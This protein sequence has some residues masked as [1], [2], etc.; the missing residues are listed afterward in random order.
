MYNVIKET[1]MPRAW[2]AIAGAVL[3][4]AGA[5]AR[6]AGAGASDSAAVRVLAH[7]PPRVTVEAGGPGVDAG[8]V[9]AGEF[10]ATAGFRVSAGADRVHLAVSATDLHKGGAPGPVPPIPLTA[11]R[12]ATIASD[13]AR[14]VGGSGTARFV[15]A[16]SIGGLAARVSEALA[17]AGSQ[18]GRFN[19]DVHVTVTWTHID[20]RQPL[21]EYAGSI[22]LTAAIMP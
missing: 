22:R 1:R 14:P 6:E 20:G 5:G 15:E 2:A 11:S 4:L 18:A 19:H 9:P 16:D 21:G 7:V 17:F 12:G 8:F 10:S 3:L 13:D